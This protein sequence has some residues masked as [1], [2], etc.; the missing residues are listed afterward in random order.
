MSTRSFNEILA[1]KQLFESSPFT[2]QSMKRF[3]YKHFILTHKINTLHNN[4][5]KEIDNIMQSCSTERE[6]FDKEI[7][8]LKKENNKLKIEN[9]ML[10]FQMEQL[11]NEKENKNRMSPVK[12][13]A[14]KRNIDWFEEYEVKPNKK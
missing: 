7:D 3:D 1:N 8:E 2:E 6:A 10:K 11:K 14:K 12:P 4:F 13:I 5:K 9:N